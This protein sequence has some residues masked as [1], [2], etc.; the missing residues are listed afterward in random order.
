MDIPQQYVDYVGE[1]RLL[2]SFF[3]ERYRDRIGRVHPQIFTGVRAKLFKAMQRCF[4]DFGLISEDGVIHYFGGDIPAEVRGVLPSAPEPIIQNLARVATKRLLYQLS[5]DAK[6]LADDFNPDPE[7]IRALCDF[8]AVSLEEDSSIASGAVSFLGDMH[9]KISKTYKFAKTGFKFLDNAMGGEYKPGSLGVGLGGPGSGKTTLFWNSAINMAEA[10]EP[11]A[12]CFFSL[13]MSKRDLIAKGAANLCNIDYKNVIS[14]NVTAA[15]A[16]QIED[17]VARLQQLP[18]YVIEKG[19]IT[20][21]QIIYE[22]RKHIN[23]YNARVFFL[24]YLQIINHHP[25]GNDNA[26]LG[27]VALVLK[28]FAKREGVTIIILSQITPGKEGV[29]KIRDSGEVA[30]VADFVF[31]LN[32]VDDG[33]QGA[34]TTVELQFFKNRFGSLKKSPIL[35]N[36]PFQRFENP[37]R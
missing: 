18:I 37:E 17:A 36:G 15:Q 35:F 13:E 23:K 29:F 21:S 9:A 14:G 26:D 22:M 2:G 4:E 10:E 5:N 31:G 3:D 32:P 1:W 6:N 30:A 34:V 16:L 7:A 25:T 8:S 20:L 11:I 33:M 24:D 27:E 19:D 28:A 12:S